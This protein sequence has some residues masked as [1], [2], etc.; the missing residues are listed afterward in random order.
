[1]EAWGKDGNSCI[2]ML[3]RSTLRGSVLELGVG[4]GVVATASDGCNFLPT[5]LLI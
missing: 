2:V 4:G 5:P 1:L 3:L